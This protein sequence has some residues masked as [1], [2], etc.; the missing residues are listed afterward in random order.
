MIAFSYFSCYV[1]LVFTFRTVRTQNN[2]IDVSNSLL[3]SKLISLYEE[4]TFI[5]LLQS[6][7]QIKYMLHYKARPPKFCFLNLNQNLNSVL[8][9]CMVR[10]EKPPFLSKTTCP[11]L[12]F[13]NTSESFMKL[14]L[15]CVN[16][17]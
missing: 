12:P 15:R 7:L 9:W 6:V 1:S 3:S 11:N 2:V 16:L 4:A 5:R 14:K 13:L 10:L 17:S 8:R